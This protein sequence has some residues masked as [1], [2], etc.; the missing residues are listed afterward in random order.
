VLLVEQGNVL[1]REVQ[2]REGGD[3]LRDAAGPCPL[4]RAT[5]GR[6]ASEDIALRATT[7]AS[8]AVAVWL[9]FLAALGIA[10][11]FCHALMT[12]AR[13]GLRWLAGDWSIEFEGV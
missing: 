8:G 9:V 10:S 5:L 4:A 2:V 13:D 3:R 6:E 7:A 12:S 1:R 11:L